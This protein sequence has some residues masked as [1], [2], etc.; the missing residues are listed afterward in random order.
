MRSPSSCLR[1]AL[2][3]S[4]AASA[5]PAR[6]PLFLRERRP[7]LLSRSSPSPRI[8]IPLSGRVDS[9]TVSLR[10]CHGA[11]PWAGA[12]A[13]LWICAHR[14]QFPTAPDS[15]ISNW[16]H[17]QTTTS[18]ASVRESGEQS[19]NVVSEGHGWCSLHCGR[20]CPTLYV[21]RFVQRFA[22]TWQTHQS[23]TESTSNTNCTRF[24]TLRI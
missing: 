15:V 10:Q 6:R 2:A 13:R 4:R 5:P 3:A 11:G 16:L 19:L 9:T 21:L 23:L 12:R 18:S 24:G 17:E 1:A 22:C 7:M 20:I 8:V 14:V